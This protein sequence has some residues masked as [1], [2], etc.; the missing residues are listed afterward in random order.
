M[1]EWR[2]KVYG[3]PIPKARAR[4]V[5]NGRR[6]WSYTPSNTKG[7]EDAIILQCKAKA[8]GEPITGPLRIELYFS[9]PRVKAWPRSYPRGDVD[10]YVKSVKDALN[11]LFYVDDV[12]II[13]VFAAKSYSKNEG[14][15]GVEI[16]LTEVKDECCN[17]KV[18]A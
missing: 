17:N 2:M 8:P 4:T 11:G 7:W 14:E 1:N 10:N 6:T 12:Q 16:L 3:V 15:I 9:I 5:S 13:S 18:D